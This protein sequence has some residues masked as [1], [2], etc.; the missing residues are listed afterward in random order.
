[1]RWERVLSDP[2][3]LT[4]V[5][6]I[7]VSIA[8]KLLTDLNEMTCIERKGKIWKRLSS[9]Q[10]CLIYTHETP[11]EVLDCTRMSKCLSTIVWLSE[12]DIPMYINITQFSTISI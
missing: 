4:V 12:K 6:I 7:Q 9:S 8:S 5:D 2:E 3:G 1:M 11:G 10:R